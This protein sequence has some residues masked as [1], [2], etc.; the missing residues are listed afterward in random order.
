MICFRKRIHSILERNCHFGDSLRWAHSTHWY[1]L[2]LTYD[3]LECS[4]LLRFPGLAAKFTQVVEFPRALRDYCLCIFGSEDLHPINQSQSCHHQWYDHCTWQVYCHYCSFTGSQSLS[5]KSSSG[6][7][8]I[9]PA[10]TRSF[11]CSFIKKHNFILFNAI[12]NKNYG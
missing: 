7:F 6:D 2:R 4:S 1:H 11:E 10:R 12:F 5:L 8:M 9:S 3:Q